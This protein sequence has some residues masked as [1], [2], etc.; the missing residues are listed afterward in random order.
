MRTSKSNDSEPRETIR[1]TQIGLI[2]DRAIDSIHVLDNVL[3]RHPSPCHGI[4]SATVGVIPGAADKAQGS[5]PAVGEKGG[6]EG[7]GTSSDF[8]PRILGEIESHIV[9]SIRRAYRLQEQDGEKKRKRESARERKRDAE[10]GGWVGVQ[11]GVRA[12]QCNALWG[13]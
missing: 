8:G 12:G 10:R 11:T 1:T 5:V 4:I 2:L 3:L 7:D 6:A 9:F 13:H